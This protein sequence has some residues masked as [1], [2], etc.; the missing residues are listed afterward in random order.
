MYPNI[1]HKHTSRGS[2]SHF[3]HSY[4][5]SNV[6]QHCEKSDVEMLTEQMGFQTDGLMRDWGGR[7]RG[8]VWGGGGGRGGGR[9]GCLVT[10]VPLHL[11]PPATMFRS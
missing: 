3:N 6:G 5:K 2:R 1:H 7:V 11:Q 4:S 9:G 8:G 10:L